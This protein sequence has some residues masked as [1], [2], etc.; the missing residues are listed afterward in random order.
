MGPC[1]RA[2]RLCP[3]GFQMSGPGGPRSLP[4]GV[5][6]KGKSPG[7]QTQEETVSLRPHCTQRGSSESRE[8]EIY[9][10]RQ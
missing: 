10:S 8:A 3:L 4:V 7:V 2:M 5:R 1:K 6:V 9:C